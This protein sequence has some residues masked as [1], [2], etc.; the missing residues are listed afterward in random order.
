MTILVDM[1]DVLEKLVCGWVAYLNEKYGI[2]V[3]P[4]DVNDWDMSKAFPMLSHEQVYNAVNDDRLWDFVEPMPGAVEGMRKLIAD[5]HEVYVVTASD[6][7]TL[8]AKMDKVLF[9]YFPFMVHGVIKVRL[10]YWLS[11]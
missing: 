3:K 11:V 7:Q 6:Y 4:E 1:D 10:I 2:S 8:R 5:G 9:R